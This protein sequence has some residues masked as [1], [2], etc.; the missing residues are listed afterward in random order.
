[1]IATTPPRRSRKDESSSHSSNETLASATSQISLG[2]LIR[3]KATTDWGTES[4][5]QLPSE[6]DASHLTAALETKLGLTCDRNDLTEFPTLEEGVLPSAEASRRQPPGDTAHGLLLNI[7]DSQFSPCLPLLMYSTRGQR[8]SDVTLL[9]Q[10][11][12]DFNPL[13]GVPDVSGAFVE[14]SKPS[15]I[16]ETVSLMDT[17][18]FS[19][20]SGD[21]FTLSQHP[22]PF[23]H[24]EPDDA[25]CRG[26]SSQR[27]SF[28]GRLLV[29]K[30][31]NEHC[32]SG[33]NEETLIPQTSYNLANSTSKVMQ[34]KANRLNQMETSL[35]KQTCSMSVKDERFSCESNVPATGFELSEKEKEL[36]RHDEFS[37]SENSSCKTVLTKNSVKSERGMQKEKVKMAERESEKCRR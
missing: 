34:T 23:S 31:A 7:H 15:H 36:L 29:S 4:W 28:S 5:Y 10:S 35:A 11:E 33:R 21:C 9:Q 25:S 18:P 20:A 16:R 8:F 14:H 13:R 17:E 3:Q 24:V 37:S 19:D 22:L 6:M 2:E 27:T 1:P 32:T 26:G 12:M 30:E